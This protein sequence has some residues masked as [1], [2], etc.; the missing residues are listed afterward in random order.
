MMTYEIKDVVCDYG[1]YEDG[2]LKLILNSRANAE[3]IKRILEVDQ[4]VPNVATR[5]NMLEL[6]C[7]V[8]DTIYLPWEWKNTSGIAILTVE[9]I[10]INKA[11]LSIRTDFWS[12]DED[13]LTAYDF[14]VFRFDEI[15]KKA[16][17]D[18]D[19]AKEALAKMKG[20]AE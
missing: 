19:E 3:L 16:F 12:D 6:P 20:G 7:N 5:A 2:E 14:G 15:G 13:Y 18:K 11:G 4:S 10:S 1:L 8:G 9:R 17:L